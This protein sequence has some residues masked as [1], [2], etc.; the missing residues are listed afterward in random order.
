MTRSWIGES[1]PSDREALEML[2]MRDRGASFGAVAGRLGRT[3]ST[4]QGLAYRIGRDDA[5]A[6]GHAGPDPRDGEC[7][8]NWVEAGLAA[9]DA[10]EAGG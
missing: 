2:T 1:V 6:H 3:R 7:G 9:Q 10:A 8:P 5:A 4:W